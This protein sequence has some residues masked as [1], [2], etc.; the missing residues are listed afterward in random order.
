MFSG[1]QVVRALDRLGITDVVWL[2]DSAMGPWESAL[3]ASSSISLRRVCRE[4]EAWVLAAGLLLGGRKP[5]VMIQST[6]FYESGD[7]LRNVLFDLKL[8]IFSFIG[9]RS[10]LASSSSDTARAFLEPILRAWGI[11]YL[12]LD[13]SRGLADFELHFNSCAERACAGAVLL[14]E[15]KM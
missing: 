9:Y 15:G 7:A 5:L 6:G 8:P 12:I 1:E 10:Y 2:P 13:E 11:N 14:P 3:E 4:G